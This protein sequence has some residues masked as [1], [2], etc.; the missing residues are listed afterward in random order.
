MVDKLIDDMIAHGSPADFYQHFALPLPSW[1]IAEL[2]GVPHDDHAFFQKIA[3]TRFSHNL[4]PKAPLIAGEQ[5]WSYLDALIARKEKDPGEGDDVIGRLVVEQIRP[6]HITHEDAI[7]HVRQLLLAG[8]DTTANMIALG[9][10]T[11]FEHPDQLERLKAD[12]SLVPNAV[13]EMLRFLS[14]AQFNSARVA[15][16]DIEIHGHLIRKGEGVVAS[17]AAANRDPAVF[18]QPD[19]F[20]ISRDASPQIAF[21]YGV[22]QCIGQP[23]ARLELTIVFTT[24]F[25]RLPG[26]RLAIPFEQVEFT[27]NNTQAYGVH[28]LPVIW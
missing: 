13:E 15:L 5:L 25:R 2:L 6:G 3:R 7:I 26:L 28:A 18:P 22:H 9:A 27:G 21:A 23:L 1:V 10:L 4:D 16:E 19:R 11:L 17:I 14:I 8:H 20:D 24:L 12:P